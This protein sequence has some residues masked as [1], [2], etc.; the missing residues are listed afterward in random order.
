M[1]YICNNYNIHLF[2]D[3]DNIQINV[4][5]STSTTDFR[6][7]QEATIFFNLKQQR[8]LPQKLFYQIIIKA[9]K[10]ACII[11]YFC[12]MD[13][14]V[15]NLFISSWDIAKVVS[16]L[17]INNIQKI[18]NLGCKDEVQFDF[19]DYLSFPTVLDNPETTILS[20]FES[21]NK[22]IGD[23]IGSGQ[24]VLVHCVYG[25]SRSA[26]VIISYMIHTGLRL[27]SALVTMK[28]LHPSMCIN[29]GFLCQLYFVQNTCHLSPEFRLA[30]GIINN[31]SQSKQLGGSNNVGEYNDEKIVLC[32][33]CNSPLCSSG[34]RLLSK[35]VDCTAILDQYLDDFWR[36]Y[37]PLLTSSSGRNNNVSKLP[38][39]QSQIA[40]CG[41]RWI[42]EQIRLSVASGTD[43]GVLK[44]YHCDTECGEWRIK[45]LNLLGI[46]NLCD[47]F[48][49]HKN[50][51]KIRRL[52]V[53]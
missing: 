46:Y 23:A 3:V 51:I 37:R 16:L 29:P 35:S 28:E 21:T 52:R 22:F 48:V 4:K 31:C 33:S 9:T 2:R 41:Q 14:I 20:C 6:L 38:L 43:H 11:T 5:L 42:D 24:N 15:K 12:R 44:C 1:V 49:L 50:A 26:S 45:A 13:E 30:G 32:K 40:I 8:N 36:G 53:S 39:P 10:S 19:I 17:Q 34:D 47:L 18:V 27:E 25:Q 7:L